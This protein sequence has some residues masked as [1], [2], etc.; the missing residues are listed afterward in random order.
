[1]SQ[2]KEFVKIKGRLNVLRKLRM[3]VEKKWVHFI[4]ICG[5]TMAPLANMFKNMGW[6]VSGSDKGIFPPMSDYL[7]QRKIDIELGFKEKHLQKVYY[8]RK[9]LKRLSKFPVLVVVGNYVGLNNTEFK[10]VKEKN[11]NF[12][13]YPE[14]LEEYLVKSNSIVSAGTYGKTT[15]SALLALIFQVSGKNPSFMIGGL[16]QNFKDGIK[17]TNSKW[18]IIEGD[19]YI[20]ARY[21]SVSKFFHYKAEFVLLTSCAWEHTDFFKTE[22]DYVLNFKKFI[23]SLPKDGI[24]VANKNGE[25]VQEVVKEARCKVI[26]YELNKVDDK[27]AHAD[28]LNLSHKEKGEMGEIVLYN[29][30]TKEEFKVQTLLIGDH[31][32]ENIIG[33]CALARELGIKMEPI[34][35]AVRKFDGIKR[36]LEVRFEEENFKLLDDHA[37]SPPKVLGSLRALRSTFSDW[38]ITI[39][40]EPN[41]GNRTCEAMPLFKG[42]FDKA[43][44]VI[45]P[46]LKPVRT[47]EGLERVSGEGLAR[48][49]KKF[50]VKVR[51]IEKDDEL[52]EYVS[53][54]DVGKH[55]VCFMGAYGWRHMIEDVIE[56]KK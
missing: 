31:N 44:E 23:G 11:L 33:C 13:S 38:Y 17:N 37:C 25:N 39:I 19:E 43:D 4:G 41:V 26:S 55:I 12:K 47:K 18:S 36:R 30:H 28:W 50:E 45:I 20:S 21:D 53:K 1:M 10:F 27:L 42:V 5:V 9:G 22:E 2:G 6:F 34:R 35:K 32:R 15:T 16:A 24:V 56:A 51:Y 54:K 48:Q 3:S 40:F 8:E 29:R 14:V 46:H 52:V 49:L 7:K